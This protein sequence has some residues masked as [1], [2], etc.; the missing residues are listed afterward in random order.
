MPDSPNTITVTIDLDATIPTN[1][2]QTGEDDWVDEP[3]TMRDLIVAEAAR[4]VAGPI[5]K[6]AADDAAKMIRE[7]AK[8]LIDVELAEV[9][10]AALREPQ[11]VTD[12]WGHPKGIKSLN[13]IVRDRVA[14]QS[15]VSRNS[16]RSDETVFDKAI[17]EQV[18]Y[19]LAKEF[20]AE[21][22]AAKAAVRARLTAKASE[23]LAAE[24]LREAGVR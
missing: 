23:L 14:S 8:T 24:T 18:D 11:T 6:Q 4:V 16:Y 10:S 15:T 19:A 7:A 13:D 5:R 17:R 22:D 2:T 12:D 9:I 1:S 20:K 21:I 3:Q